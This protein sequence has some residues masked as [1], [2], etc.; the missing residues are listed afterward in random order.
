MDAVPRPPPPGIPPALVQLS[1]YYCRGPWPFAGAQCRPAA[2]EPGAPFYPVSSAAGAVQGALQGAVQ[3][4][5]SC[6]AEAASGEDPPTGG[7]APRRPSTTSERTE[8]P[9]V[10]DAQP[11]P[12]QEPIVFYRR[13]APAARASTSDSESESTRDTA[14]SSDAEA[15]PAAEEAGPEEPAN[16]NGD[17]IRKAWLNM[18]VQSEIRKREKEER[19]R[20]EEYQRATAPIVRQDVVRRESA[21]AV[22]GAEAAREIEYLESRLHATFSRVADGRVRPWPCTPLRFADHQLTSRLLN[23]APLKIQ[24]E[25][26]DSLDAERSWKRPKNS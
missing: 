2:Q 23:I 5:A 8:D 1:E 3:D 10:D 4:S 16:A 12:T 17:E 9:S 6:V 21:A 19:E 24:R 15:E 25:K 26:P 11:L 18:F 14:S 7:L 20:E 13:P 22:Y